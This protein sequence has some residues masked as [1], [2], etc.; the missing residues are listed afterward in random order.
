[1]SPSASKNE[2]GDKDNKTPVKK[3][4]VKKPLKKPVKPIRPVS[5][6]RAAELR[7]YHKERKIWLSQPEHL[8]CSEEGCNRVATEVH[9]E[10]GRENLRLLDKS[11]WGHLCDVHHRR[12][13]DHSAEAI[14]KGISKPRVAIGKKYERKK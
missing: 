14:Q 4:P 7:Q 2:D 11:K 5:K 1:M 3:K 9:H 13:T 12:A 8:K 6:K 10:E